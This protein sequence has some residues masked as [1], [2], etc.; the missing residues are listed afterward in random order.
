MAQKKLE[1]VAF[2]WEGKN[3]E[4]RIVKGEITASSMD[5]VKAQ[6]RKQGIVPKKVRKKSGG[7][8][9]AGK[10]KPISAFSVGRWLP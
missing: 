7:M 3:K 2:S 6:L 8:F 5:L 10:G 4:G 9:G 1:K